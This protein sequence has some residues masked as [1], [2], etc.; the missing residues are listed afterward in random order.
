MH[1]IEARTGQH[2]WSEIYD[3]ELTPEN[4]FGVQEQLAADLAGQ[5]A[6]PYGIIN[7]VTEESFRRERPE[8][9]FAYDCVLRAF[10][11]RRTQGQEKHVAAAA[12][13]EEAVRRDPGYAD[14]WALLSYSYLN[15]FRYGYKPRPY[16]PAALVQAVSTAMPWSSTTMACLLFLPYRRCTS[17]GARLPRPRR[18]TDA[19]WRAIPPIPRCLAR[20]AGAPAFARDWDQGIALVRRAIDRSIKA[21]WSYHLFIALDHYREGN[22]QAALAA[23]DPI[24]G[25][26][27]VSVPVVLAAI[28]GQL[29]NEGD[30]QRALDRAMTLNPGYLENPR[31]AWS[32]TNVPD[33]L[34][35]HLID[36]LTKAGLDTSHALN[37]YRLTP[38]G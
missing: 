31:A 32:R 10:D 28:H 34:I 37:H 12:C 24:A 25:T 3:R 23:A 2:L 15:E 22:Y 26:R 14:A 5:L 36:G 1:L 20:S 38:V 21:P 35:D 11:A 13:L 16:D 7:E 9:L 17:I 33:D 19:F 18:S 30:A 8:T 29:G 4:V 27:H 6:Q